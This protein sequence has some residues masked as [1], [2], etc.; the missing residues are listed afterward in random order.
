ML[1]PSP[2][3]SAAIF[4]HA[5][6]LPLQLWVELGV[7]LGSAVMAAVLV[8]LA[9]AWRRGRQD[10]AAVRL[11]RRPWWLMLAW[12]GLHSLL[13][14]PLWY[15]FFLLPT[16]YVL[17]RL[18]AGGDARTD[19]NTV[20]APAASPPEGGA[21]S[22]A[23][24]PAA[25]VPGPSPLA[26]AVAVTGV[27]MVLGSLFAAWD[28]GRVQQVFRPFGPGLRQSLEVRI[29]A[30]RR[31]VLFGHWVDYGLVTNATTW[32]GLEP[33]LRR[34]LHRNPNPHLLQVWAQALHERGDTERARFLLD[35]VKEFK[36]PN[37]ADFLAACTAPDPRPFACPPSTRTFPLHDFD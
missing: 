9:A 35:R 17:G 24:A 20:T 31:S 25:P 26:R 19:G 34:A 7:P 22:I 27:L 28:Y 5:H 37:T 23:G 2:Q 11:S 1:T 21:A 4:H 30:G 8:P 18:L 29:E 10:D 32:K 3:R 6:N 13:E 36:N 14:Y 16:A 15:P 33:A 12:M